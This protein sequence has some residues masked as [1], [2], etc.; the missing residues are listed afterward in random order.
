M[1]QDN[2]QMTATSTTSPKTDQTNEEREIQNALDKKRKKRIRHSNNK[3][4]N[5][6]AKVEGTGNP[7]Y[8]RYIEATREQETTQRI[9]QDLPNCNWLEQKIKLSENRQSL[10]S[11]TRKSNSG[12]DSEE[13]NLVVDD[14]DVFVENIE[15]RSNVPEVINSVPSTSSLP[16]QDCGENNLKEMNSV[17]M[18][19]PEGREII[20]SPPCITIAE[21]E[22]SQ[23]LQIQVSITGEKD[24]FAF[25]DLQ[26]QNE[27]K[28]SNCVK[29]NHA[30][31]TYR[32][33]PRLIQNADIM[34]KT[35]KKD[36]QE[37][38]NERRGSAE[39]GEKDSKLESLRA[40]KEEIEKDIESLKNKKIKEM[41]ELI[42]I[43]TTKEN[44]MN[45]LESLRM[46]MYKEKNLLDSIKQQNY[47]EG[48]RW[49]QIPDNHDVRLENGDYS[50]SN[51][52]LLNQSNCFHPML[53]KINS[54]KLNKLKNSNERT[55]RY[56]V[57]EIPIVTPA[58][59]PSRPM[60]EQQQKEILEYKQKLLER[61]ALISPNTF[62][63]LPRDYSRSMNILSAEEM[64]KQMLEKEK[65]ARR[66]WLKDDRSRDPD[67]T[68]AFTPVT[69]PGPVIPYAEDLGGRRRVTTQPY[70]PLSQHYFSPD[71]SVTHVPPRGPYM[72]LSHPRPPPDT[73]PGADITVAKCEACAA[74]ALFMCSA[75]KGAHY[76]ST[77][78]QRGH[79]LAHNMT[80][81]QNVRR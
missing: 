40:I 1:Y 48:K 29:E 57:E 43:K 79:W 52:N 2:K 21:P 53:E 10:S 54:I 6:L 41:E 70:P 38:C 26:L 66:A 28:E 14:E 25:D 77:E 46:D 64:Y 51:K 17:T 45:E 30:F 8:Q 11:N 18:S 59:S 65:H 3:D 49:Q 7:I 33:Q 37:W 80:C 56:S 44:L 36:V 60:L 42:E 50:K 67:H 63:N 39:V 73:G 4:S 19:E 23:P 62:H 9:S 72:D 71:T 22:G 24:Q 61:N 16:K 35:E 74:P 12:S 76:C 81:K 27:T 20:F 78:C 47:L 55:K 5:K 15:E 34:R 13:D 68:M 31:I 75:C 69:K 58:L 32:D